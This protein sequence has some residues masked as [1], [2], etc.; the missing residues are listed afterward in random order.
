MAVD[1]P[2]NE[3]LQVVAA[4]RV[5]EEDEAAVRADAAE[6]RVEGALDVAVGREVVPARGLPACSAGTV[7]W[8]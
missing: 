7:A 6:E 3:P 1:A 5:P 4:L 8:R 2:A